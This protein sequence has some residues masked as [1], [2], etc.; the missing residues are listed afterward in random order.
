MFQTTPFLK[1]E[2]KG[3]LDASENRS[4]QL[5]AT[6]CCKPDPQWRLLCPLMALP[7][8]PPSAWVLSKGK[9]ISLNVNYATGKTNARRDANSD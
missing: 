2:I 8:S 3:G 5:A 4:P 1:A 9:L 7:T 6:G